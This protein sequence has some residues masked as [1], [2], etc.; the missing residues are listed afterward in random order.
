MTEDRKSEKTLLDQH[1]PKWHF[2]EHHWVAVDA[3]CDEVLQ[4]AQEITWRQA[5]V[6]R[7]LLTFTRNKLHPD[8]RVLDDFAM[9][10]DTVLALNET[11]LLYGGIGSQAGPVTPDRPMSEVFHDYREPGCTKVGFNMRY[12]DGVLSTETRILATDEK[13][14]RSFGH[15]WAVI[16]IPSGL[17][18]IALLAAV[19]RQVD[20]GRGKSAGRRARR[21]A[22]RGDQ[23]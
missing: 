2:R 5:P 11:E 1:M 13:T 23:A 12:A 14:R 21:P 6:A 3:P 8:G 18:R 22:E 19:K 10:G 4:A 9:G 7:F 16:R 20:G 17:I 15:Y